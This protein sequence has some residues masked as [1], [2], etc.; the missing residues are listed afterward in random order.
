MPV[1]HT[2][3]TAETAETPADRAPGQPSV[4]RTAG[5]GGLRST[6]ADRMPKWRLPLATYAVCQL[7]FIF[8]WAGF[9]PGLMNRDSLTYVQHVTTGPWVDNHSVLYDSMLWLSLHTTG[10]LGAL[11]LVQTVAMAAALAYTVVA[12]RRL[13]VPGRWTAVAAVV[14]SALP[15]LGSFIVFIW[16]DVPFSICAY[17]VVPTVAH[18]I[19]LRGDQGW[20][21]DRRVN[22]LI[23][24]LGLELLGVCLFRN[25]GFAPALVA[26]ALLVLLLPG[27]RARLAGVAA[28]AIF[29]SF[30]LNLFVYPAVG[31]QPEPSSLALGPAYADIAVAYA[32]RPS[33]FTAADTS[34]MKQVAPLAE[35]KKTANCYDSDLT[36]A[37]PG[38]IQRATARKNQLFSLWLRVLG[39]TPDLILGAR[40]CR[41]S[42]AWLVFPGSQ[43]SRAFLYGSRIPAN[44]YGALKIKGIRDNPYRADL[45]TR[46][47]SGPVNATATFLRRASEARQLEWLLWRGA[48]WSYVAYLVVWAVARRRKNWAMLALAAMVAGEQVTVL[49]DI[50]TQAFRYMATPIFVG[51]MLLPL[52]FARNRAAPAPD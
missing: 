47:L 10:D 4:A 40:I 41:G 15:P 19:S 42:I 9:Y 51:I 3:E 18:L 50:P 21:N 45:A 14:A 1:E 5:F 49:L 33:S 30:F 37:I 48:T 35:W 27:V 13:G 43:S 7:I 6:V 23:V 25:N 29:A 38:F 2:A 20:R 8:W 39:R 17:L 46:P 31:I 24:A 22:R 44:L 26:A 16:K 12:F 32:D 34:L 36:T 52:F 11:T 28:A